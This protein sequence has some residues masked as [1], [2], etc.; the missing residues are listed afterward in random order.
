PGPSPAPN[1]RVPRAMPLA[2]SRGGALRLLP[3]SIALSSADDDL[4][5]AV[6]WLANARAG[7]HQQIGIAEALDGDGVLRHAVADQF[8]LHG[9]RSAQR[10]ALVVL[11]CAGG[12]G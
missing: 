11:P 8:R 6:L 12:V 5:A 7:R 4:D 3:H 9:A 1:K 10:Q 2:G